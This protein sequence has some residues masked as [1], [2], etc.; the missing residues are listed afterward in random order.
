MILPL[1]VGRE[2]ALGRRRRRMHR[3]HHGRRSGERGGRG[4]RAIRPVVRRT[5]VAPVVR[6]R[7]RVRSVAQPVSWTTNAQLFRI[8]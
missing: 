3:G 2:V 6:R 1:R 8:H 5:A 7:V 4:G